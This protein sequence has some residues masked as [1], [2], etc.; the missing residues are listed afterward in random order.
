MTTNATYTP[1]RF[2]WR[3]LLTPDPDRSL[4]FYTKLL[5]WSVE[6]ME[7]EKGAY[8]ALRANGR[9]VGGVLPMPRDLKA[10][11]HWMPYVSTPDLE[12]ATE[13]ARQG[14]TVR[15]A[16]Q[17]IP[18]VGTFS[19]VTDPQGASLVLFRDATGDRAPS[20]QRFGAGDFCW[21]SLSATDVDAAVQWYSR[22]VGWQR[23]EFG[24]MPTFAVGEGMQNAVAD[25]QKTQPGAPAHWMS[26]VVVEDLAKTRALATEL[27]GTV[28]VPE[29]AVPG[30]GRFAVV[31][32]NLG[33]VFGP[34]VGEG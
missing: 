13:R 21:E 3:E 34:F 20:G 17:E 6:K 5:G 1:G 23:G 16:L 7:M 27:G 18:K 30:V 33:A 14:G 9:G 10:P 8:F 2:V 19:V 32:D 24:G 12:A 4:G 25:V 31:Q 15:M 28:L 11:A 26:F 29:V 22:V